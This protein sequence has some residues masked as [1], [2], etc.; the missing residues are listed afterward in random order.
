MALVKFKNLP[1]TSTPLN[2]ENLNNNF[3]ELSKNVIQG[4]ISSNYTIKATNTYENLP[5]IE[6]IKVGEKLTIQNNQ[7]IVGKNVS[8]IMVSAKMKFNSVTA[9]GTKYLSI[10]KN[11]IRMATSQET[12]TTY[13]TLLYIT[14]YLMNVTE[15]DK[16]TLTTYGNVGDVIRN[17]ADFT[18]IVAEV[19]E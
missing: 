19:I 7:I 2:A 11:G 8:V 16:I 13:G 3:E 1:D 10:Y 18:N 17:T 15:G 6:N 4:T 12:L 5:I 14:P 9:N